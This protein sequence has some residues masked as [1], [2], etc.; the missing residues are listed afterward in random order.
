MNKKIHDFDRPSD[1]TSEA[2]AW[3]AQLETGDMTHEDFT[4]FREW[5]QRSPRHASEIRRLARLSN[6][7]NVLT[8][9]AGPLEDAAAHFKQIVARPRKPFWRRSAA[10]MACI[11][12]FALLA[13]G[14]FFHTA[15][16]NPKDGSMILATAI[17]DYQETALPDGS[18]VE[19]NSN[20]Q[21]EIDFTRAQRQVRLLRGEAYFDVA[22][23]SSRPFVVAAGDNYVIAVG[24][25]FAVR[26]YEAED[27]FEV[28]VTEGRVAVSGSDAAE[29][30]FAE[31]L[32]PTAFDEPTQLASVDDKA[33]RLLVLKAGQNIVVSSQS[34]APPIV[35][36]SERDLQRKLSWQDGLFDFSETPLIEVVQ[37]VS[38]HTAMRIEIS[39]PE[40]SS[41]KFGGVFRTGETSALLDALETSF[42]IEVEH[43][44]DEYV[45]L[46]PRQQL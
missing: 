9:M 19:L 3:I 21:I 2:C 30:F 6:E 20:T 38:R 28:T 12:V 16:N 32:S 44:D 27:D 33:S 24:T 29:K 22:H 18:L 13:G 17:G 7:L 10:I 4:A 45:R 37:E 5:M 40:L 43:V 39:D 14:A 8:E 11:A 1:V 35:E 15:I 34:E 46:K 31:D 36:M 42:D 23:D 25:A 41:L 26:L